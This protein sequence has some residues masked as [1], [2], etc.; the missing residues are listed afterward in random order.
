MSATP[1]KTTGSSVK[2]RD[3]L[4]TAGL[5]AAG[6]SMGLSPTISLGKSNPLQIA[7][8]GAAIAKLAIYPSIGVCR[9]GNSP[10]FF[11]APEIPGLP[12]K[13]QG[14]FKDGA[15]KIK[16]QAQRFR[17]YAFDEQGRV[18][19]EI[20]SNQ[21]TITWKVQ[22]A[23]TK[24]A[25]YEFN[26]PLDMGDYAP[27]LSGKLRNSFFVGKDREVLEIRSE[28]VHITGT[29]KNNN[30]QEEQY[31]L[32]GRF[33]SAPN[34]VEVPLGDLRTDDQ[35]RLIVVPGNGKSNSAMRQSPINNFS[36]NDGWYDDWADGYVKAEVQIDGQGSPIE[37][38]PAWVA[39]CGPNFAPEI[40][41]FI[42]MYDVVRD[43]MLH[44]KQ[45]PLINPPAE[46]L[47]FKEEI[48]PFFRRLGLMEWTTAAANFRE[49]WIEIGDFLDPKYI[50]RLADNSANDKEFRM[51]VF[52]QFR[53]PK[54][55]KFYNKAD[56]FT[57]NVQ[58]KIPYMLGSGVNYSF[59]P[60]HWFTMPQLQFEILERWAKGD[61][62]ND[63]QERSLADSTQRFED[64]PLDQQ[65]M[66]LIRAA[67][68]P[69]SG[70]AFHPGV[71]L[72]WPLRQQAI[73]RDD[74]PFRIRVQADPK[75][76]YE[77][78][79]KLGLLLT[80]KACFGAAQRSKT[81]SGE[82]YSYYNV[83]EDSPVAAQKPGDL[84]RWLGLPW[85]P[86]AFSCQQVMYSNDF[87]NAA[88]WPALLPIDVLPEY[89]YNQ[90]ERDDLDDAT[91]LK[92]YNDRQSWSRGVAGIGYHVQGSYDDG[93]ERMVALWSAM[94]FVLKRKRPNNLSADLKKVIPEELYVETGRG[95]MDLYTE[96]LPNQGL[97]K[98]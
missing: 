95:S 87:P 40:P 46:R 57:D 72:T 91:K 23:N 79:E 22:L 38:E 20:K 36:D 93:L 67:L 2:R 17:V 81:P 41:A 56:D 47:S 94:G 85:H 8:A 6:T 15:N 53:H 25:W 49:G 62:I 9:V 34:Q 64:I 59:S 73:Y 54:D 96:S 84:T 11:Y 60:A 26:N 48:Y 65:P 44:G 51:R 70:G 18:I 74:L 88:W 61:F 7:P 28:E 42:T 98:K 32:Q 82:A 35:G 31:H 45:K 39:C 5:F 4:A 50:A 89:C 29:N 71:E 14:G 24:A 33:W 43:V 1:K 63:Y 12:P 90:L 77:Q 21:D 58:Y 16:K 30:G 97:R 80:P 92:F 86:D 78:T 68:E 13:P 52:G 55:Y 37:V 27:G 75:P 10:E 76:V 66:A 69:L 19:R 83:P 3:F